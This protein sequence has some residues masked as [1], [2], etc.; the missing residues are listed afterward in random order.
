MSECDTES[1][2][3][4]PVVCRRFEATVAP[5]AAILYAVRCGRACALSYFAKLIEL[6]DVR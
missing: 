3:G 1:A 4:S 5:T 6:K 2:S